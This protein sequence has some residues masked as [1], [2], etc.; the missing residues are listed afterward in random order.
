MVEL[1]TPNSLPLCIWAMKWLL[2]TKVFKS[3]VKQRASACTWTLAPYSS[4]PLQVLLLLVVLRDLK[5]FLSLED[6]GPERVPNVLESLK[7]SG[8]FTSPPAIYFAMK[9][10]TQHHPSN[11]SST[12]T[13]P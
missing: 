7:N 10:T 13:S 3:K 8:S 1:T 2:A 11:L 4:L 12:S 5:L 9:S 6:Q